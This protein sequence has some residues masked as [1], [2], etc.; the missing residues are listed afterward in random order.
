MNLKVKHWLFKTEPETYSFSQLLRD[1]HTAW[2]GV[3]NYQARNFLK[4]AQ[5]GDLVVIYHSGKSPSAV[6]IAR[7]TKQHIQTLTLKKQANGFKLTS[8]LSKNSS[9]K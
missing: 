5:V 7:V 4:E 1:Q 6:G 8:L 3:R 9:L 2:N